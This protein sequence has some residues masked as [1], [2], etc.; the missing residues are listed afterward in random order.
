MRY[1]ATAFLTAL[2]VATPTLATSCVR[3]QCELEFCFND[4]VDPWVLVDR[5]LNKHYGV[6]CG[7]W[8]NWQRYEPAEYC[9]DGLR[10]GYGT[11]HINR[12]PE[13]FR[14]YF[15]VSFE[16]GDENDPSRGSVSGYCRPVQKVKCV[17]H[18]KY[19]PEKK[20]CSAAC[21]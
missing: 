14:Q 3:V 7:Q 11:F 19:N 4:H 10:K 17:C 20:D 5:A 9:N 18:S 12:M 1:S 21:D 2:F 16:N 8:D 6:D 15:K 13:S